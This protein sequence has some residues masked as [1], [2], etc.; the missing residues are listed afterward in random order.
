MFYLFGTLPLAEKIFFVEKPMIEN[1][2]VDYFCFEI[3][4]EVF[5]TFEI[6]LNANNNYADKKEPYSILETKTNN[7]P[8]LKLSWV[9][10]LFS[11][12]DQE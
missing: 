2:V 6:D 5:E 10:I 4:G 3:W 8:S 7:K 11:N 9:S 1:D 12:V